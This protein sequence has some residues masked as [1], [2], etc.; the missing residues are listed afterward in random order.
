MNKSRLKYGLLLLSLLLCFL[1]AGAYAG[2]SISG[3][4]TVVDNRIIDLAVSNP[5]YT[6]PTLTWT[7]PKSSPNW[8]PATQYDIRF[9]LSPINTEAEW[10]AATQLANTPQPKPP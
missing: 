3:S 4:F 1:P 10:P 6:S 2:N 9:S 7:S 5:T 8:G